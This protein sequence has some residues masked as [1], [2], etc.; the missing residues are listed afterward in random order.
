MINFRDTGAK[1]S[2]IVGIGE[3]IKKLENE[4]G[5]KYLPLNRGV[6][7]VT[8]IDLS[9]V[10]S[11]IDFNSDLLQHYP[12]NS[13]IP[14]LKKAINDAY[15]SGRTREENLI[16]VNGGMSGLDIL[17]RTLRVRKVFTY[18]YYWGAYLNILKING[19]SYDAYE[20]FEDLYDRIEDIRGNAVIICDPNNPVGNKFPD[21]M[22]LDVIRFLDDN[23][24]TVIFDSP[25]R[26]LFLE[27]DFYE[28]L[29]EFPGLVICD[30]FSKSLGLSGQR[31]G[32]LHCQDEL[33]NKQLNINLLYS[34]NG[35]NSF[36]QFLIE[37][38]LTTPEGISSAKNFK[39]LTTEHVAKNIEYLID[40]RLLAEELYKD[41]VPMGI[42]AIIK[43]DPDKLLQNRIGSVPVG[44]FTNNTEIIKRNYSRICVSVRNDIFTEYFNRMAWSG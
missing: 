11:Q 42:F 2:S 1:Y 5:D 43:P 20:N 7:M 22:L 21:N 19:L 29:L 30:S 27:D 8:P 35:I 33:F 18:Q 40:S 3:K 36:S 23:Q 38:L 4:T 32:F 16:I 31:I 25:Y 14:G 13:G 6:T 26:K 12:P 10:V 37:K 39:A 15:F 44:F 28:R 17:F 41:S 34:T 24:V 9:A